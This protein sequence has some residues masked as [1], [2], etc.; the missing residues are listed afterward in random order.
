M[1]GTKPVFEVRSLVFLSSVFLSVVA[2]KMHN[3]TQ[4]RPLHVYLP[5]SLTFFGVFLPQ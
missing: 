4:E 1:L 5:R 3:K 2:W